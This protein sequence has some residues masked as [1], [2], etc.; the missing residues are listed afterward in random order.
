MKFKLMDQAPIYIAGVVHHGSFDRNNHNKWSKENQHD[1]SHVKWDKD[2]QFDRDMSA[3]R[4]NAKKI[5]EQVAEEMNFHSGD[6]KN[7]EKG[8]HFEWHDDGDH[9]DQGKVSIE[10]AFDSIGK[11]VGNFGKFVEKNAPKW[12]TGIKGWGQNFEGNIED[13]GKKMEGWGEE[14]GAKM[15]SWG[16]DLGKRMEEWG[17]N[18]GEHWSDASDESD[19][20]VTIKRHPI[21]ETYENVYDRWIKD[22]PNHI[23]RQTFYEVQIL[24][25]TNENVTTMV[26]VGSRMANIDHV[27]YPVATMTFEPDRWVA[28]KLTPE[29]FSKDWLGSL[30]KVPQ[31][32]KYTI[33]P[34]FIIRHKKDGPTDEIRL[35]CPI[36]EQVDER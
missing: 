23:K 26:M 9:Q 28:V 19:P 14:F 27:R 11:A 33:E 29:E 30:E 13:I 32:K 31:L 10:D 8:V 21:Y 3:I 5:K 12:E 22:D 35:F 6:F 7:Q 24:A 15:E 34:Y 20:T 4:E 2:G 16:D 1:K 17:E 25:T 18:F 36:S